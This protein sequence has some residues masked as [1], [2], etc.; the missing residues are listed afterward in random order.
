MIVD[1]ETTIRKGLVHCIRW[2]TLGCEIAAQA[3][4]GIEA[5]EQIRSVHPDI[6]ISDIRMPGMDGLE[7]ARQVSSRYPEIKFIILTGFPDF[8][9][10]QR[11]I[12]Y[13]VIDFVLKPIT[14]ENLTKAIE[15]AKKKIAEERNGKELAERL[16][17]KA[18]QNLQLERSVFL[19]NLIQRA[20]LSHLFAINQLGMDLS[21]YH[22]LRLEV[23][24]LYEDDKT[25]DKSHSDTDR[26]NEEPLPF[27]LQ[28]QEI[29][30]DSLEEYDVYFAAYGDHACHAVVCTADTQAVAERCRE[31]IEI[32]G[33][34]PRYNLSIGI[35]RHFSDP[36][37]LADAA[38]QADQAE[39]FAR[40]SA[41]PPV[42]LYERLPEIPVA[43]MQR[44]SHDLHLLEDAIESRSY[45]NSKK[46]LTGL[47]SFMR[48]NGLSVDTVQALCIYI[49]QYCASL[50]FFTGDKSV[51]PSGDETAIF[52]ELVDG[53]SIDQLEQ[54]MDRLIRSMMKQTGRTESESSDVIYQIKTYIEEHY[55]DDI[56]L[57]Q[58]AGLVYLSPS[59]LSRFFKRETGENISSFIQTIRIGHAKTL[60]R[61]SSLK[62]YEVAE[63]VGI[64]DPVY[65]SRIFKK[66]TG[67]KPK[68]YRNKSIKEEH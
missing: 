43:V 37:R 5:L 50:V 52:S 11:A 62:T 28:V 23:S 27:V 16:A 21:N 24:P 63:R 31:T 47:F 18:E 44:V 17:N 58:L 3:S 51:M 8:A 68:D 40:Y 33:S 56:K 55:S 1:N 25:A 2:E 13:Q 42:Q 15:K 34:L 19:N 22:V 49:H 67:L 61:T 14:I 9:Y 41:D 30:K 54:T 32:V 64:P 10:A 38:Q 7:L 59:Y 20:N 29:L 60:L 45:S 65:F 12:E 57:E 39:Q 36:L 48:E 66:A 26:F 35:S 4:D 6:I 46:I 53:R